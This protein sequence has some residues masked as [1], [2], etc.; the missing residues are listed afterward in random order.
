MRFHCFKNHVLFST[1]K[2]YARKIQGQQHSSS[3]FSFYVCCCFSYQHF[4]RGLSVF[5]SVRYFFGETYPF[6]NICQVEIFVI[7]YLLK[8]CLFNKKSVSSIQVSRTLRIFKNPL[9]LQFPVRQVRWSVTPIDFMSNYF[10][11]L[12]SAN[13]FNQISELN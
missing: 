7:V 5:L 8:E 2:E 13:Y 3:F 12:F 1:V 4:F 9:F 6:K 11:L 10:L